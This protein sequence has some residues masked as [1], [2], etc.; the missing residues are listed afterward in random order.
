MKSPLFLAMLIAA[1][2]FGKTAYANPIIA[3]EDDDAITKVDVKGSATSKT[4]VLNLSNL[5]NDN[6]SISIM[7]SEE[8]VIYSET[9]SDVKTF[10]KRFNLSQLAIGRYTLTVAQN[11][12]KT[13][14]PF[15]V[16][17]KN[18]TVDESA[19]KVRFDPIIKV[20]EAKLE[21][22]VPLSENAVI[23]NILDSEGNVVFE[24]VNDNTQSFRKRYDISSLPQGNYLVE[25]TYEGETFY[26]NI[27]K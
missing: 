7:D 23:I 15:D 12:F 10:S 9:A 8:H 21:V 5:Q 6:V 14:Q 17:V 24:E 2:L 19:K 26:H 27:K 1:F 16:T 18:V 22:N 13:I 3:L 25:V 4:M 11:K 20:K